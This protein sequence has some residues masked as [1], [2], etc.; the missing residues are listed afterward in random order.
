MNGAAMARRVRV[1]AA[2]KVESQMGFYRNRI[3]KFE[4]DK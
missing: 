2:V 3:A 1:A 4:K